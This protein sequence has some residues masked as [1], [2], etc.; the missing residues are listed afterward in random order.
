MSSEIIILGERI[1]V[2]ITLLALGNG[3]FPGESTETG[4]MI[5]L[6]DLVRPGFGGDDNGLPL[7]IKLWNDAI[8]RLLFRTG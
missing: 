8:F 7:L 5:L 1:R 2:V 4:K 6:S 3:L